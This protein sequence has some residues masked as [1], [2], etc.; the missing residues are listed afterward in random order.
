MG[1]SIQVGIALVL[2]ALVVVGL[3][4]LV[5]ARLRVPAPVLLVLVGLVYAL[6]PG[7]NVT[8]DPQAVLLLVLPPLLY[9]AA[10]ESSAIEIRTHLQAVVALSVGLV[11]ATAL[12]VGGL[13]SLVAPAVP[14]AAACALGACVA[15][16]D[17]VAALAIA[18]KVGLPRR[19]VTIIEG[20]S[21]V[22]DAAS[23]TILAV[24]VSA[25]TGDASF[26]GA[27]GLFFSE[28]GIGIGLGVAVGIVVAFIRRQVFSRHRE[29]PV[30]ENL[31]SLVTPFGAALA[32]D[33]LHG[34][35]VLAV[36]V[37]G[38]W[39]GHR[40]PVLLSPATR[41]QTRA[42]AR[43]VDL[44]LEGLVFLLIGNQLTVVLDDGI[45]YATFALAA[46]VALGVV[47][48]LRPAWLLLTVTLP[49]LVGRRPP[50]ADGRELAALS[51]AGM[52]G[53]VSLAA[54][55][56]LPDDFPARDLLVP[57]AYLVTLGT[58]LLLGPTFAPGV[59]RL[60][61]PADGEAPGRERA[62]RESVVAAG[63]AR[64]SAFEGLDEGVLGSLRRQAADRLA[65]DEA[66]EAVRGRDRR[67]LRMEMIGAERAELLR[68]RGSGELDDHTLRV[69]QRE[70]DLEERAITR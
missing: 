12:A 3:A 37:A 49:A 32:A 16:N 61:I 41:L 25:T 36:V 63:L 47:L 45:D 17:P 19:L 30:V 66:P 23:L 70:L 5:A 56:T 50:T 43:L 40:S 7:P 52:R 39:V 64:L 55:S 31:L 58:L 59:R 33:E 13:V 11:I 15:P 65:A 28:T 1:V 68:L 2:A 54:I 44:I 9:S 62:A 22:N 24:A 21:L 42:V 20:E 67:K 8:L 69:V 38:L 46:V 53:V 60:R 10:V 35:G 14:F 48:L 57:T 4:D 26:L 27:F 6:L 34:S 29:E 18:K 51:W